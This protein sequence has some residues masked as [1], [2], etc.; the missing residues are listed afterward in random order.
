MSLFHKVSKVIG[1]TAI[2]ALLVGSVYAMDATKKDAMVEALGL[3][4]EQQTKVAE[5]MKDTH[6]KR[7]QIMKDHAGKT[8]QA[9]MQ[10]MAK[11]MEALHTETQ[12]KINA[13]LTPEQKMKLEQMEDEMLDRAGKMGMNQGK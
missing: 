1:L 11:Q 10:A 6:A 13:E 5:I 8:G 9:D 7:E 12:A 3:T 4:T 2:S